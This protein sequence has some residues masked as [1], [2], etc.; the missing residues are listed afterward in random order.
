ML[1]LRLRIVKDRALAP[2]AES[3]AGRVSPLTLS[4][5]S[6]LLCV[7]AG[8]LAWQ[9]AP[10]LAVLCWLTGRLLDGLDGPVAR[11]SGQDSDVGGYTDLLLD[12]IGYA[13][14]P[15]GVAAGASDARHWAIA[16]VL[17]A[18]FYVN[19]VSVLLLSA[20]LEKRSI[21]KAHF[22]ETT[23]I[24]LPPALVE[25]SETILI[26]T[27]ALAIPAWADTIFVVM[28]LGVVVSVLQ[29]AGTARR[30]LT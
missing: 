14:I 22:G 28:A 19:T 13:A 4:V 12:T 11:S 6:M 27:L 2:I 9:S 16:A 23:T 3:L 7:A 29:R 21:G 10:A 1:D 17:L 30:L 15:L 20:I 24:A 8:V 25:G 5:A 26:F 18:T